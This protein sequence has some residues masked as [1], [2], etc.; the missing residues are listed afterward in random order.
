MRPA[1]VLQLHIGRVAQHHVKPA[2]GHRLRKGFRPVEGVNSL[3]AFLVQ[4]KVLLPK[5]EMAV[6]QAVAITDMSV[7]RRKRAVSTGC[8]QPE[9]KLRNSN[10][11]GVDVHA[12]EVG[13]QNVADQFV[14]I[15]GKGATPEERAVGWGAEKKVVKAKHLALLADFIRGDLDMPSRQM[16]LWPQYAFD[17][18]PLEPIS[19]IYETF[20]T[21]RAARGGIFYTPPYLVDF[22]L[23]DVLPWDGAE[24][25]L[26]IIDPACG[27]GVFL[28]K[29]F[30]RLVHRWRHANPEKPIRAESLRRLFERNIVG[31]DIDPR[32]VRV[33][34][35]SLYLAMCDEMEPR[36]YC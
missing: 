34:C 33:A 19:S 10:G 32:A 6:D 20:V 24:W 25:N 29:A 35:F 26:K 7:E 13:P 12:V 16:C 9:R 5:P 14:L 1:E 31:V 2:I 23:D 30:Q 21:E 15:P 18:I 3:P 8:M 4:I 22:V 27:S 11:R 36:H 28:V 17:V